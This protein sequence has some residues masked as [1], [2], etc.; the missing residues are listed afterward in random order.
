VVI[1]G[2]DVRRERAERVEGG[3]SALAKLLVHVHLDL[4]HRH[5][6][7]SLDHDLAALIPCDLCEF[8]QRLQFA[9]PVLRTVLHRSHR[10]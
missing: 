8:A 2:S 4:V 3:F 1:S 9:S 10:R 7:G 6:A 5:M